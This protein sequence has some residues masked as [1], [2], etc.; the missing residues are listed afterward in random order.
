MMG[1]NPS[2][3]V[4]PCL[5]PSVSAAIEIATGICKTHQNVA[6]ALFKAIQ[7]YKKAAKKSRKLLPEYRAGFWV[8]W[9]TKNMREKTPTTKFALSA[10]GPTRC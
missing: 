1:F 6:I 3:S 9:N 5:Q 8:M 4:V 10:L 7:G 2:F